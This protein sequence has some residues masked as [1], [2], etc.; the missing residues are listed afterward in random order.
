[1]SQSFKQGT[2]WYF[3]DHSGFDFKFDPPKILTDGNT[4]NINNRASAIT[5]EFGNLVFYT[6]GDSVWNKGH[7]IMQ[8]GG[9]LNA[10][11]SGNPSTSVIVPHPGDGALFYIFTTNRGAD[12]DYPPSGF[13]YSVID[14]FA[15]AGKGNVIQK[16]I[17]LLESTATLLS[18]TSHADEQSFWV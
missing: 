9:G 14:I 12:N 10:Y 11:F 3:G 6:S 5:D 15:N 13:I 2:I 16:N 1:M 17:K 8:N 7:E 18:V 4:S